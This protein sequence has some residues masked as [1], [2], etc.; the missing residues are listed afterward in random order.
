MVSDICDPSPKRLRDFLAL[1][2]PARVWRPRE[3]LHTRLSRSPFSRGYA[4]KMVVLRLPRSRAVRDGR[5]H[6]V[7]RAVTRC[8]RPPNFPPGWP[9]DNPPLAEG[10]SWSLDVSIRGSYDEC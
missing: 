8:Q 3:F 1:G 6:R 9:A 10:K 2:R 5:L 7:G 4:N